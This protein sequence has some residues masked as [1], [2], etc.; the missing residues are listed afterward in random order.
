M[1]ENK[2][3]DRKGKKKGNKRGQREK[4]DELAA[5]KRNSTSYLFYFMFEMKNFI[6]LSS[7]VTSFKQSRIILI[8]KQTERRNVTRVSPH[9]QISPRWLVRARCHMGRTCV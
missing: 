3:K 1:T 9:G 6:C 5:G 2:K 8:M 4:E 7:K